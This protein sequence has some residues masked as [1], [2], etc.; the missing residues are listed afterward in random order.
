[1]TASPS[2][3]LQNTEESKSTIMKSPDGGFF[4]HPTNTT[5]GDEEE[6]KEISG[7]AYSG[8]VSFAQVASNLTK[9]DD[10]ISPLAGI[11]K[12]TKEDFLITEQE[13]E[14][15]RTKYNDANEAVKEL[16]R[17]FKDMAEANHI[18]SDSL[19]QTIDNQFK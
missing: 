8:E 15:S 9:G 1:M 12:V 10:S 13:Y 6:K 2:M 14:K 3:H 7:I 17:F 19:M 11:V 5:N 18:C 4:Q 16:S